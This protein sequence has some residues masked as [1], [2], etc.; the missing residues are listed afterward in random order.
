MSAAGFLHTLVELL[1][2]SQINYMVAGSFASTYHG[3]P[4]TTQDIDIVVELQ[5]G[6]LTTLL[7]SLPEDQ[8]YVSPEAARDA[9]RWRRQFNIIDIGTGWKADLIVR[10]DRTFSR[11]EFGRRVAATI[12]GIDTWIATPEDT[13][14]AKLEWAKRS[15]SEKQLED[16]GGIVEIVGDLLDTGYIDR[17]APELG[18]A[19]LWDEIRSI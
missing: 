10:K 14:L 11:S 3:K 15:G 12:L 9:L 17:W 1:D 13:L 18:V 6:S 19:S 16:A 2:A 5:E 4:R 7:A 8:F